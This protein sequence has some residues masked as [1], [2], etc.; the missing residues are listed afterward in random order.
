VETAIE[1]NE[2]QTQIG[3]RKLLSPLSASL[4][5]GEVVGFTAPSGSGKTRL[6]ET[7]LNPN[8]PHTGH[9]K[10]FQEICFLPQSLD[11]SKYISGLEN[12]LLPRLAGSFFPGKPNLNILEQASEL[13]S[14]LGVSDIHKPTYQLSG[15]E[16][17]RVAVAR[18]LM[19][20]RKILIFDEPV[21]QLD[22]DS[23]LN[24]LSL[25]QRS[26]QQNKQTVLCSLHQ[27][28]HLKHFSDRV[29]EWNGL[30]QT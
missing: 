22:F 29:F 10:A 25:I 15:G 18:T 8:L 6:F 9:A 19:S 3:D 24:C 2:F 27:T 21:S 11:L 4:S 14:E 28:Q 7:L 20:Q 12:A 1:F 26:A 30:W 16:Q 23:A 13:L 5:R 17:Q